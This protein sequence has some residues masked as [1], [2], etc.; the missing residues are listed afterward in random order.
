M[1]LD[2]H[3]P[4]CFGGPLD[5]MRSA[6]HITALGG[7]YRLEVFRSVRVWRWHPDETNARWLNPIECV[8]GPLAG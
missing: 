8:H 6:T 2:A 5:G 7:N 4:E 1:T 3:A